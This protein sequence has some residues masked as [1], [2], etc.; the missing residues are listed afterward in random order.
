MFMRSNIEEI[1]YYKPVKENNYLDKKEIYNNNK[2]IIY[3]K[4]L[5]SNK[6]KNNRFPEVII[7][8]IFEF[9]ESNTYGDILDLSI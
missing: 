1:Y 2:T 9:K 8:L 6:F 5:Y 7:D 3:H 4:P